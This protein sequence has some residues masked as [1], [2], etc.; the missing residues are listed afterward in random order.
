MSSTALPAAELLVAD[1]LDRLRD[2]LPQTTAP[3]VVA[4]VRA[5]IEDR[6]EDA[7]PDA[8]TPENA[9][10]A[11]DALGS[12]EALASSLVGGGTVVDL[13]T[14]RAFTRMLAVV[15]AGHLLLSIVLTV[16][17]AD[18]TLVPGLVS[19]LPRGGWLATGFGVAATFLLDAGLLGVLFAFFGRRRS[20]EILQ[21]LQLRMPV[22]RRDAA[23]SL[24]LLALVA[25]LANVPRFRDAL[26]SIGSGGDRTPVLAPDLLELVP[27]FDVVLVLFAIRFAIQLRA[28]GER[29]EGVAADGLA[30]LAGAGFCVL[31]MTRNQLVQI[32]SSVGLSEG[33]A[34]L[35]SD[36]ILRVTLLVGFV[37]SL[38]L[39]SRF[40][41]RCLRLR[42]LAA[43]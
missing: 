18:A 33:A 12:P 22:G 25:M 24:V 23:G 5:L 7:G 34:G 4:E 31:L 21:R 9:R 38:L 28:G 27:A 19:A 6:L 26:F 29:L 37:A 10:R 3:S 8:P 43:R 11:L 17:G 35:F 40:A 39:V 1:Y 16:I 32:P 2:V 42:Q 15:F 13:A 14:R 30:S 36:L 41:K 20:P